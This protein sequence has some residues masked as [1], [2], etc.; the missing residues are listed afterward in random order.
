MQT[1]LSGSL[2]KELCILEILSYNLLTSL[3][4]KLTPSLFANQ[5]TFEID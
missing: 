2:E 1:S 3:H 4:Q 5:F